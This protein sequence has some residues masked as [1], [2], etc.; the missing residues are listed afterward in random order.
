MQQPATTRPAPPPLG[1]SRPVRPIPP[2]NLA[3]AD[4]FTPSASRLATLF[5]ADLDELG[6]FE[7]VA[8]DDLPADYRTLLAHHEH[9]TVALEVVSQQPGLCP[10]AGRMARRSALRPLQPA[11]SPIGRCDRTIRNHADLAGRPAGRRAG[12]K[13]PSKKA[14]LGRVLID[15]NVLREVKLITLWQITPGPVLKQHLQLTDDNTNLRP[16]GTNPGR[17]TTDGAA[18]GNCE[19]YQL[20]R[21]D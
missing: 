6:R 1:R 3:E 15:H 14:P 5:F 12:A 2:A 7:P 11:E 16:L 18:A 9:M 10:G 21:I 20:N 17:R 13:S 19:T 8:V 4:L